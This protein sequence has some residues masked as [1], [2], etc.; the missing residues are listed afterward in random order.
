MPQENESL[1]NVLKAELTFVDNGGY[2]APSETA[3]RPQLIFQDSP[4]CLNYKNSGNRQSCTDCT[5]I[6]L[7]PKNMQQERFPCRYIPL[8]DS[9]QTLDFLYRTGTEEETYAIL[10]N[11]LRTTIW[12]LERGSAS[13]SS[14]DAALEEAAPAAGIHR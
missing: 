8:D 13:T 11:W 3:W 6:A 2:R 7:V 12:R 10:A 4:T 5:L 1:L 14:P 9:G